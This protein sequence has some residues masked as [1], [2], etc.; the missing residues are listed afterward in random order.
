MN[1]EPTDLLGAHSAITL[2]SFVVSA[3]AIVAA[4]VGALVN[5]RM[6]R[7]RD[8]QLRDDE[9]RSIC[10]ALVGE[11]TSLGDEFNDIAKRW[12][13]IASDPGM[14]QG[15]HLIPNV[16]LGVRVM[17]P[18]LPKFGLLPA[19]AVRQVIDAYVL[20]ERFRPTLLLFGG[21]PFR[22]QIDMQGKKASDVAQTARDTA[23]RIKA[24]IATLS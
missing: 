19:E 22:E 12:D 15:H 23:K 14:K 2:G 13:E 24:A 17:P 21:R 20:I 6:N 10:G 4:V 9:A 8:R 7:Q 1:P 18:L 11:L 5:A 16:A 3:L